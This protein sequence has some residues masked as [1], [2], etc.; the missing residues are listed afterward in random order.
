[1]TALD[2]ISDVVERVRQGFADGVVR[3][4]ASR[5]TQL[6][7]LRRFL[8]ECDTE[9]SR[10]L[11][12]DLGKP[13][14]EA[15]GTEIG[16]TIAEIDHALAHVQKWCAP[17][18]VRVPLTF[19]PATAAIVPEPLGTVLII[20]PWNYPVQLSLAPLVAVLAAGNTAVLKLSEVSASTSAL[21]A[22]RL[23]EYLDARAVGVVTGAVA[24]S[25]ALLRERFDHIFFTGNGTVA[26]VVMRAAAEH[27]TPVTLELGG[28]S[29][30]IVASDADINIA[31]R[32]IVWGKFVNAGQ[33]CLAPDYVLVNRDVEDRLLGALLRA[34]HDMYGESPSTS[35]DY[36][37]IVSDRH[38]DRLTG[39]LEAGG[40]E[41]VVTGGSH[42]RERR[43]FAPTVLAGVEPDATI[44]GEEIFGP[45][46]AVLAVDGLD[47]A[48]NFVN[49]RPKPLALYV[50]SEHAATA[51]RLV[52]R[53]TSG[54]VTINH[55]LLHCAV[56]GLPFGGVGDSGMGAYHGRAGFDTF[57]H[58]KSVLTK[59]TRPDPSIMY[60]PYKRWKDIII[61]RAL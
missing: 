45:I 46:L 9:I 56:N 5:Q 61:R 50:F 4:L 60:P 35:A 27:L 14:T 41:A 18:K 1:M 34:I 30:V 28:K 37:R 11:Q 8:V 33:T 51:E 48:V 16:F 17:T 43:Y 40:F 12:E 49:E 7:Q 55:T 21:L 53:T 22:R 54:G 38:F 2:G 42:N 6:R 26:R 31:A 47:E 29:P 44:M 39:L 19:R 59:S 23:P 36:G 24:E 58:H 52:E 3:D 57:S 20:A 15:Y 25:T 10:A 13:A 32:R